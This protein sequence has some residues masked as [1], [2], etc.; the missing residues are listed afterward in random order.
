MKVAAPVTVTDSVLGV[1][2]ATTSAAGLMSAADKV[3]L[4]G[5][6]PLWTSAGNVTTTSTTRFSVTNNAT[7]QAIY[8]P[9]RPLKVG[10]TYQIVASYTAGVV[11]LTGAALINATAYS[12]E[13]GDFTRVQ[14]VDVNLPGEFAKDATTTAIKTLTGDPLYWDA[15]PAQLVGVCHMIQATDSTAT[16]NQPAINVSVGGTNTL[17]SDS[18]T[19]VTRTTMGCGCAAAYGQAIEIKVVK[20][21]G[22]TPKN[23]ALDLSVSLLFIV[24]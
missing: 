6:L 24:K 3:K 2:A 20:A 13:Y 7:N 11:V 14:K 9:G 16:G 22:G 21:T 4:D 12:V 19:A 18:V 1:S 23:D 8:A 10:S 5:L 17:A 15:G